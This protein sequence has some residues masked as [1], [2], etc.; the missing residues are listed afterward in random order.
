VLVTYVSPGGST[1]GVAERV[2]QRLREAG[3]RVDCA[4][5][6]DV[7]GVGDYDGVVV[8]SA[9]HGRAWLPEAAEFLSD[10]AGEL[11]VRSV[12]LFSVGMPGALARPLRTM[13]M[14]EG[15][16][17]VAPYIELVRPRGTRLFSGVVSRQQ[18]PL[19]SRLVLRLMGARFGDFRSWPDIDAWADEITER[20]ESVRDPHAS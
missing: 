17:A 9:L 18:F 5:V 11:V 19:V 2:A 7:Q 4:P 10:N 14:R 15:P 6:H 1:R 8:G 12:W 20:L 16:R 13:A 3:V